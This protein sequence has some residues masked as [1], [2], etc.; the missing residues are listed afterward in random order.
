MIVLSQAVDGA[1][2]SLREN[3]SIKGQIKISFKFLIL[4]K[5]HECKQLIIRKA[6]SKQLQ[7]TL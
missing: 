6:T 2:L 4:E 7:F 3:K 1:F 5:M